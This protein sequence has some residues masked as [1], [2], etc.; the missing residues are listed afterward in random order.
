MVFNK[1]KEC[2]RRMLKMDATKNKNIKLTSLPHTPTYA[3]RTR[4]W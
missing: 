2:L 4:T 3:M 1:R